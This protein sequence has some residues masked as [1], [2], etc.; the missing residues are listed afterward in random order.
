MALQND[1]FDFS[2]FALFYLSIRSSAFRRL[3]VFL[4]FPT[5]QPMPN[6]FRRR[7]NRRRRRRQHGRSPHATR[8]RVRK[9]GDRATLPRSAGHRVRR[10]PLRVTITHRLQ[11]TYCHLNHRQFPPPP[12]ACPSVRIRRHLLIDE[13]YQMHARSAARRQGTRRR[14]R[15]VGC[16]QVK[17]H[18][19]RRGNDRRAQDRSPRVPFAVGPPPIP[20]RRVNNGVSTRRHTRGPLRGLISILRG[21]TRRHASGRRRCQGRMAHPCLYPS[22]DP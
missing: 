15:G 21:G 19:L 20:F 2:A 18:R 12:Q 11:V 13:E 16:R 6:V 14:K 7:N 10:V 4:L 3:V 8:R 9:R 17:C 22:K 5:R 1:R